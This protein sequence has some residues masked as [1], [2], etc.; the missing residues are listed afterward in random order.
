M[1]QKN[2]VFAI[3][4]ALKEL[5][6]HDELNNF[7][8]WSFIYQD[9]SLIS[10][11]INKRHEPPIYLGY[12]KPWE[13]TFRPKWH[14]E[15]DAINKCKVHLNGFT[16]INIR[17]NKLGELRNAAPCKRCL[18]ILKINRCK[19]VYFSTSKPGLSIEKWKLY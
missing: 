5:A 6:Q 15:M 12:H 9:N 3:N 2:L 16:C 17:L 7:A 1:K 4:V 18:E 13:K 14:S 8:H 10:K 11:G 19:E